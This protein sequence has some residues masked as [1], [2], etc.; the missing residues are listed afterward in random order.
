MRLCLRVVTRSEL[1]R[2]AARRCCVKVCPAEA[3]RDALQRQGVRVCIAARSKRQKRMTCPVLPFLRVSFPLSWNCKRELGSKLEPAFS[4][5]KTIAG[6]YESGPE[7]RR[8]EEARGSMCTPSTDE[9]QQQMSRVPCQQNPIDPIVA[10]TPAGARGAVAHS[11][12]LHT[13]K[14]ISAEKR[15]STGS[16]WAAEGLRC[17]DQPRPGSSHSVGGP[18]LSARAAAAWRLRQKQ[19]CRIS[20][21][22][23][24][25][26]LHSC[27]GTHLLLCFRAPTKCAR[28]ARTWQK[29]TP[30]AR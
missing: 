6:M 29:W 28:Q 8:R 25:A 21:L 26:C 5:A 2:S 20:A 1:C 22:P 11:A 3:G 30:R 14:N 27:L 9:E 7:G 15:D 17:C 24:C 23:E 16:W 12:C 4:L 18:R 10:A 13:Q 19:V